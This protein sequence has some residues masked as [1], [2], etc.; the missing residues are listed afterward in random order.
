M[1]STSRYC[2]IRR[3]LQERSFLLMQKLAALTKRLDALAG[4]SHEEFQPTLAACLEACEELADA[5]RQTLD[6]RIAHRC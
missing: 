1:D 3:D 2:Q 6:H 4:N 5:R